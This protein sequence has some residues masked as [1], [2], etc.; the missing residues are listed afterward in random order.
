MEDTRPAREI[1][2][3][4]LTENS[5]AA[6]VRASCDSRASSDKRRSTPLCC[7]PLQKALLMSASVTASSSRSRMRPCG[8]KKLFYSRVSFALHFCVVLSAAGQRRYLILSDD[9]GLD[10]DVVIRE[11]LHVVNL[12]GR[13]VADVFGVRHLQEGTPHR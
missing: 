6:S 1:V 10:I 11:L 5:K 7:R 2:L 4:A 12:R 13:H 3:S 8:Q 9:A